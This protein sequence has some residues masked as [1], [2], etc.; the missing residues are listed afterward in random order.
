[1]RYIYAFNGRTIIKV[2][3]FDLSREK[4]SLTAEATVKDLI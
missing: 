3:E 1:M 4:E 2:C